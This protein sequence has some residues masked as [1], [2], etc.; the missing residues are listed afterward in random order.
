LRALPAQQL[1]RDGDILAD[2]HVRKEP[3]A[4]EHIA[5]PP[6]QHGASMVPTGTPSILT[7]PLS[8]SIKRLMNLSMVVLPE[9]EAPTTATNAPAAAAMEASRTAN[10][11]PPSKDLQ[12][13]SISMSGGVAI[14]M[15]EYSD[16]R[17]EGR[18]THD[19]K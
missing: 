13:S 7:S 16:A 8:G 1:W 5:D 6:A 4:L 12:T 2:S 15:V 10:V 17:P 19:N 11:R 18:T 14:A 3:D 9:P